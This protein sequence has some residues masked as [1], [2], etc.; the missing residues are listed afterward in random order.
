MIILQKEIKKSTEFVRNPKKNVIYPDNKWYQVW[1]LFM[2]LILLT[3]CFLTP[4]E[5]AFTPPVVSNH[6]P[7]SIFEFIMD[8]LFALDVVVTFFCAY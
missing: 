8:F 1:E 5:I 4:V 6:S 7:Q 3:S 2:T